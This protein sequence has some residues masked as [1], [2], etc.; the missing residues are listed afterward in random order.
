MKIFYILVIQLMWRHI[1]IYWRLYTFKI[2]NFPSKLGALPTL[3]GLIWKFYTSFSL[4]Y[5]IYP[6]T[7]VWNMF[8]EK[9]GHII[10]LCVCNCTKNGNIIPKSLETIGNLKV[11][12]VIVFPTKQCRRKVVHIFFRVVHKNLNEREST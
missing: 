4:C 11:K 12:E 1:L 2:Q 7:F 9:R 6:C 3:A 5:K 8:H 10:K